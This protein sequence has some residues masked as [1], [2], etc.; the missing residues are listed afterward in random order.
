MRARI[1]GLLL[2]VLNVVQ[3]G[4]ADD[5][6]PL[7]R[8]H[9]HNDYEHARPLFDA[10]DHG[11]CSVEADIYLVDGKLLV[12]HDRGEVN[13]ARTLQ[14]LYLDPLRKR[15]ETNGGTVY[16]RGPEFTLLIDIKSDAT[17]TYAALREVLE[18]YRSM[19]TEF[20]TNRTTVKGLTIILSGNR[21]IKDLT[22]EP[23]RLAGIDGRL[24]DLDAAASRH[25]VPWISDNWQNHFKWRG[26]GNLSANEKEKLLGIVQ[27]VHERAQK[28]RFW[29][30]GDSEDFW[31]ELRNAGVDFINTD[32][33]A[34]LEN[35]LRTP[36]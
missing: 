31:R 12:A 27:R 4:I 13:S 14:S 28:L 20:H 6:P 15:V 8:A 5:A 35:F 34:G 2:L 29:A 22:A 7:N 32:D 17:K 1:A 25:L 24:S 33:L 26:Q 9:A 23:M 30:T 21:P 3:S 10:L 16:P 11:F 19:L 18:K 36:R